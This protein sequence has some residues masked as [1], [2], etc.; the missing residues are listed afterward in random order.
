MAKY[1]EDNEY[2]WSSDISKQTCDKGDKFRHFYPG[3]QYVNPAHWD[4]PQKRAKVCVP[5]NEKTYPPAGVVE[6]RFSFLELNESGRVADT[7][8]T[9]T[10]NNV[11]SIL[12][13][14]TYTPAQ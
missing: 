13:K 3:F 11:G 7:E 5:N 14:F 2:Y 4:I 12:P 8:D 10:Q 1:I 6:A 9:A